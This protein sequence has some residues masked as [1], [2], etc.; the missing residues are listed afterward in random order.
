MV[1]GISTKVL[2]GHSLRES[3]EIAREFGYSEIEFWVDDLETAEISIEEI[4]ALTDACGIGRSV[5]LKTEDLN[6]A[7]F[8]EA[9][10]A[11]SVRQQK[12]GLHLAARLGARTATLHP[13]RKTAKTHTV[14][15]AWELQLRSIAGLQHGKKLLTGG[16]L[17]DF[18][19]SG[20]IRYRFHRNTSRRIVL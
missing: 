10:R 16:G 1:L 20:K 2:R 4:I 12:E 11:E 17:G 15:A 14:E 19:Q 7:P 9:I 8:N 6:I 18:H 5:H 3:I 13:G